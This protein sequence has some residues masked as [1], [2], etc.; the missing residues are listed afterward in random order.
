MSENMRS[1]AQRIEEP[2]HE[3]LVFPRLRL[4]TDTIPELKDAKIDELVIMKVIAKVK[5][6]SKDDDDQM[7]GLEIMS[8]AIE[9]G[10]RSKELASTLIKPQTKKLA[11]NGFMTV[12]QG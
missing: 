1:L 5:S 8:A 2:T 3:P 9:E 10:E 4:K 12:G 7:I 11:P 6:Q